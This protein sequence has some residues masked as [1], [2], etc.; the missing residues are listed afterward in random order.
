[1]RSITNFVEIDESLGTAGQPEPDQFALIKKAG[2]DLVINLVPFSSPEALPDEDELVAE[3]GLDYCHIPV[4]WTQPTR[5]DL[6]QFFGVLNENRG[7]KV[8]AHCVMNFR[9]SA[10]VF[11]YQ[12]LIEHVPLE[13]ARQ[14]MLQVWTPNDVWQNFIE[15]CLHSG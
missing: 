11:L 4:I 10:F 8:F 1:M 14:A 3:A 12:A 15:D 2:Y 13:T 5:H 9:V 7:R 6:E